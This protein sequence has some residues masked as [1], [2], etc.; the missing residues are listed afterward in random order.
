M[1]E[2]KGKDGFNE[3]N[4]YKGRGILSLPSPFS[5]NLIGP[6]AYVLACFGPISWRIISR[7]C[8]FSFSVGF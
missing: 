7:W 5:N 8:A 1:T 3:L 4:P 6:G 2:N